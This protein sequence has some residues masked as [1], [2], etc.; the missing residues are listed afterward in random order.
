MSKPL[1]QNQEFGSLLLPEPDDLFCVIS[2]NR[3][4]LR[5]R[6]IPAANPHDA[7]CRSG[8]LAAFLEIRILGNDD[9]AVFLGVIPYGLV[10]SPIEPGDLHMRRSG[11]QVREEID[12]P[13]GEVLVEKE[14]HALAV[15]CIRSRSAA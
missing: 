8:D 12:Q 1:E 3:S 11:K 9:E 2:K 5:S 6:T 14:F 7:R 4:D 13:R 10:V 15:N